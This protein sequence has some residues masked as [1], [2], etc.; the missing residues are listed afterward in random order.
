MRALIL[1]STLIVSSCFEVPEKP[2]KF[3][4]IP[5]NTMDSIFVSENYTLEK[6]QELKNILCKDFTKAEYKLIF[7]DKSLTIFKSDCSF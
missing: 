5:L 4:P 1:L 3:K 2:P 6:H 7:N